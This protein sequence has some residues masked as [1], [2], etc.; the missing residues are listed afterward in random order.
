M[1]ESKAKAKRK[2][3]KKEAGIKIKFDVFVNN[4]IVD[5]TRTSF[6]QMGMGTINMISLPIP[7]TIKLDAMMEKV[8]EK[9]ATFERLRI[10]LCEEHG[11]KGDEG[12]YKIDPK[13]QNDFDKKFD[14]LREQ[15][16]KL[17][18]PKLKLPDT[19]EIPRVQYNAIKMLLENK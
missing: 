19:V 9:K 10:K 11:K 6:F 1:S 13:K 3:D 8:E 12:S 7:T 4:V 18:C 15:E 2:A 5:N 17:D 16:F 14:E